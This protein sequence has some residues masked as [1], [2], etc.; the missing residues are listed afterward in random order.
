M[1]AMVLAALSAALG[2]A[3]PAM[4]AGEY[5]E[6][7]CTSWDEFEKYVDVSDGGAQRYEGASIGLETSSSGASPNTYLSFD[8]GRFSADD[9]QFQVSMSAGSHTGARTKPYAVIT[10]SDGAV[11]TLHYDEGNVRSNGDSYQSA[12]YIDTPTGTHALY[13]DLNENNSFGTVHIWVLDGKLYIGDSSTTR[14][15]ASIGS[16][17]LKSIRVYPLV[18]SQNVTTDDFS[19]SIR[20]WKFRQSD[21]TPPTSPTLAKSPNTAW[22]K[23][24]VTVTV[25]PGTDSGSGVDRTE[26]SLGG[27]S[28]T[29][30]TA[31]V[32]VT[33]TCTFQARTVDKAGNVSAVSTLP[34]Q[35][36]KSKPTKPALSKSP[37]AS[38]SNGNVVVTL[39]GGT[40]TGGSGVA[41]T[42]YSLDGTT[43]KTYAS[44]VTVSSTCTFSARTTDNAGNA[45]ET[46]TLSIQIDPLLPDAWS[47]DI[48]R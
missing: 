4:A 23:S 42:E 33:S 7:D 45:S 12:P 22:A 38:W 6:V 5:T 17:T 21:V 36:D 28:W 3:V 1:A 11:Y 19:A 29:P 20:G 15:T 34:V 16:A 40:D 14:Y 46:A 43:W 31:P 24:D 37:T 47:G 10:L 8:C 18:G 2:C 13:E 27:S 9:V 48:G 32:K 25:T 35:I 26:Y 44:P 39:T 30:Y 41:G